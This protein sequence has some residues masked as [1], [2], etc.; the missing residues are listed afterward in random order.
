MG[1]AGRM[2]AM[3]KDIC[4]RF[5]VSG[6]VQGVFFRASTASVA[7]RLGLKGRASNMRDGNVMVLAL[8]PEKAVD[9]LGE[10]LREGPPSARV[11]EVQ[12]SEEQA[13]DWGHLADFRTG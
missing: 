4:R 12:V 3:S 7:H 13:R 1:Q 11:A 6:R 8:G 2:R 9:E 10:W 5:I